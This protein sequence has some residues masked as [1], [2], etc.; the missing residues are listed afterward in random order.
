MTK[1]TPSSSTKGADPPDHLGPKPGLRP[2]LYKT[3]DRFIPQLTEEH[4]KLDEKARNA[5]FAKKAT[6]LELGRRFARKVSVLPEEPDALRSQIH[7]DRPPRQ[8][9]A[10]PEAVPEDQ[11]YIVRDGEVVPSTNSPAA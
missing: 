4:Y 7:H 3:L 2:E 11:H 1:W 5:T 9:G 10:A 6:G 8:P